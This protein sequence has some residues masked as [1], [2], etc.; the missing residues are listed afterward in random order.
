MSAIYATPAKAF[1][2]IARLDRWLKSPRTDKKAGPPRH[3]HENAAFAER[4]LN[5]R[6]GQSGR[7]QP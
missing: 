1:A 2:A 4:V 5:I 7:G 6:R 3:I